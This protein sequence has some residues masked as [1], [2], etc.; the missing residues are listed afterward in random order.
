MFEL[1]L[2]IEDFDASWLGLLLI[3]LLP[4]C[5]GAIAYKFRM[6]S[7]FVLMFI[8]F[9]GNTI[10]L[11]VVVA[12]TIIEVVEGTSIAPILINIVMVLASLLFTIA[13]WKLGATFRGKN[14]WYCC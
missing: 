6:I 12:L 3:S 5:V 1:C 7:L 2:D 9:V 8:L 13:W 10:Y 14:C 11:I 4:K